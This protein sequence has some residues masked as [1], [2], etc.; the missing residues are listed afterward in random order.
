MTFL[1][2][3]LITRRSYH[4]L[5]SIWILCDK[6]TWY[7]VTIWS[8]SEPVMNR[9]WLSFTDVWRMAQGART[10]TQILVAV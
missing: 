1:D 6:K 2:R 7:K 5:V 4:I 9:F 8:I 10:N 3:S